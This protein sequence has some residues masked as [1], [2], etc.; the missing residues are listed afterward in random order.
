MPRESYCEIG[1]H[2]R[3][4]EDVILGYRFAGDS[5]PLRIGSYAIIRSGS[6]LYADTTI[7]ERF[8]C[9]HQA[10]I[11][12][13][14]MIGDRVVVHHKVTL[15]GN[16][17]I[18]SGVKIMA[19]VYVP[20]RTKIGDMV[21]I[22]PNVTILNDKRPMRTQTRLAPVVIEDHVTIGGGVTICPGVTVGASSFVAAG[23]V[24]TKDVPPRM[25]AIGS[26]ARFRSLPAELAGG[27]LPENMLPQTDL[28]GAP[29]DDSW[30]RE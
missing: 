1:P 4:D 12:G 16:L 24:L 15:E 19:H 13:R 2:G 7:G 10:L 28:F 20:S 17:E 21:F 6:I 9:G 23:A 26:P 27:N 8:S 11:R 29:S 18:G 5:A 25:L 14:I 3:I 22:G 30:R